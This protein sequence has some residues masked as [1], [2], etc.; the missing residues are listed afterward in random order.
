MFCLDRFVWLLIL[1][2]SNSRW[3]GLVAQTQIAP[4]SGSSEPAQAGRFRSY[5]WPRNPPILFP[6][7]LFCSDDMSQKFP[8]PFVSSSSFLSI[9]TP[10]EPFRVSTLGMPQNHTTHSNAQSFRYFS[11]ILFIP[12]LYRVLVQYFESPRIPAISS[13]DLPS[14]FIL[15]IS[16]V[17]LSLQTKA[18]S[19]SLL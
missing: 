17:L 3:S 10:R 16:F 14:A 5:S 15:R 6:F 4:T 8:P 12:S 2:L 11:L 1:V 18:A 13:N 19:I 9:Y 7:L